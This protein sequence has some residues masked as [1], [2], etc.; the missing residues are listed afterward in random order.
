[1]K[2][3]NIVTMLVTG[4]CVLAS[5]AL[6][7]SAL[8]TRGA[9]NDPPIPDSPANVNHPVTR[10]QGASKN[11]PSAPTTPLPGLNTAD[12]DHAL[13]SITTG[14]ANTAIGYYSLFSNTD[15][16]F[17]TAVGA[18]TLVFNVGDQTTGTENTAVGTAALL[19]NST[20]AS[21]TAV[22]S[23]TLETNNT[24]SNNTAVG[25]QAMLSNTNGSGNTANGHQALSSNIDGNSNTAF[26][27]VALANH[28]T[29][30]FN[31]AIGNQALQ[32]DT[33][34]TGNTAVGS[35]A[36]GA[37]MTGND[38]TAVGRHAGDVITG[39]GNVCI[40]QGVAGE[41]G[42]DN[43]TYI[44]NVNTTQQGPDTEVAFVTVRLSDNRIGHQPIVM[45]NASSELQKTV[46]ELKSRVARQEAIINHQQKAMEALVAQVQK[47]SAQIQVNKSTPQLTVNNE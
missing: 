17:N 10:G 36:L 42:V 18:A 31:T 21:N 24:G 25:R 14:V 5:F 16:R 2:N 30:S 20:G 11:A 26:G 37:N 32:D 13:F 15:G 6:L 19:L 39:S 23:F 43:S 4:L 29:G 27:R 45:R 46:G 44:R 35:V 47:I 8:A 28:T 12:G 40:G 38:N 7:P 33:S 34:G 9:E 3:R 22:G 1:M 41:A